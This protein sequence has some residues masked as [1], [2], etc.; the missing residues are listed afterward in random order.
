MKKVVYLIL[1]FFL[2]FACSKNEVEDVEDFTGD[3][4]T[5]TDSRD[6]KVYK[7]LRI[8]DQIWMA[9]NLAFLPSVYPPEAGS[10]TEARYYVYG[11]S[12]TDVNAGKQVENFS[13]YGVLYNWQAAQTASPPGWHLPSDEEWKQLEQWIGMT[14][15]QANATGWRG[16]DH[17]LILKATTSWNLN[18]NGTNSVGFTAFPGGL[19][20]SEEGFY[21]IG[22]GGYWW[23]STQS[24]SVDAW[25]RVLYWSIPNVSRYYLNKDYGFS[26]RCVKD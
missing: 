10:S 17:G 13:K 23:S 11:Y 4:G 20:G 26:I 25:Y 6:K 1:S 21:N 24:S 18:G 5:F 7:W 22:I 19:R 12:G 3:S 2:L 16:D 15:E 14:K 8:G 9:E